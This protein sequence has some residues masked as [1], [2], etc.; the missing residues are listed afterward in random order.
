ME[1]GTFVELDVREDIRLKKEPYDKI[2]G[3]VSGLQEGQGLILHAP[4]NPEPLHNVL[5]RK[6]F[7]NDPVQV[8]KEHWKVTYT[9][10]EAAE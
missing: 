3:A 9:K 5:A 7:E 8:E 6:G 2:M 1:K 10:K 4:F